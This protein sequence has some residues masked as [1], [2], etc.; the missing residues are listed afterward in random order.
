MVAHTFNPST[1]EAKAGDLELEVCLFYKASSRTA[2]TV[3]QNKI[4]GRK[5][6]ILLT[7]F[8]LFF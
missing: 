3:A 6:N 2:R 8:M 1:Q 7:S 4:K 5:K